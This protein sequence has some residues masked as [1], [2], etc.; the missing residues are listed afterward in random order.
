[1]AR[2]IGADG[3]TV[4]RAVIEKTY[5]DGRGHTAHEGPY[6]EPGPARARVT[7]WANRMARLDGSATGR[8]EQAHTVWAPVGEQ[9]DPTAASRAQA[10][11]DAARIMREESGSYGSPSYDYETGPGMG[12]AADRLDELADEIRPAA[13][14]PT[15]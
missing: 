14:E 10:Y 9:T 15:A 7:F 12:R 3:R 11:R 6:T 8:V 5:A 2:N 4:Y 13:E 1:M